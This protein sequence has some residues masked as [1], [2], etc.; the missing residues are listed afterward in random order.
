[1][2]DVSVVIVNYNTREPLRRCLDSIRAE[3]GT[4]EVEVIVVDNASKDDSAAMIRQDYPEVVLIEP[5]RNTWF[6]GGNNLGFAQATADVIYILNADT[7]LQPNGVQTLFNYLQAHPNV[8]AVT[9]RM[10]YPEGGLQQTCSRVPRYVDLL[11]GYTF[12][13]VL[14]QGWRN[15]R[16]QVM[17]YTGWDRVSTKV[18]EVGPGS[19]LLCKAEAI[20]RIK[21][22]DERLKLYFTED[23]LC[24]QILDAGYEIHFVEGALLLHEER[25][26]TKQVWLLASYIYFEDLLF[27][28]QKYYGRVRS[29][30]L[31]LLMI[32]TRMAMNLAQRWRGE[33]RS[34]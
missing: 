17:W 19:N 32:P 6:S 21:G 25:A 22:F 13:G 15:R 27:F 11:L 3:H 24:K 1:M 18:I 29:A 31:R 14:L 2:P 28:T 23:D 34:L 30:L 33:R 26:S 9:C 5:G 20:R 12:L 10:E 16:R 8:G 7:R 4:L